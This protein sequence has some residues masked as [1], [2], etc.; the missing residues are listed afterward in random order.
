MS[1]NKAL[2]SSSFDWLREMNRISHLSRGAVKVGVAIWSY[3][4]GKME[5]FPNY[6]HLAKDCGWKSMGRMHEYIG[7]LVDADLIRITK[8]SRYGRISNHYTLTLPKHDMVEGSFTTG[9][10]D[11][12]RQGEVTLHDGV[13]IREK[14]RDKRR[15]NPIERNA[16]TVHEYHGSENSSRSSLL[17]GPASQDAAS[18]QQIQEEIWNLGNQVFTSDSFFSGIPAR[19]NAATPHV[20][21]SE[22]KRSWNQMKDEIP[23]EEW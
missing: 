17:D 23:N 21:D 15:D 22:D 19:Q 10:N 6:T 13:N 9:C 12:A 20:A 4:F 8:E 16:P 5:A 1:K 14:E 2:E 7:E 3:N 11:Q 18:P